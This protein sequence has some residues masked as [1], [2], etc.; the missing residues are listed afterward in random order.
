MYIYCFTT[1]YI[2]LYILI[3]YLNCDKTF[4]KKPMLQFKIKMETSMLMSMMKY[5][6]PKVGYGVK[7]I[8]L[9]FSQGLV[10]GL[11]CIM[12]KYIKNNHILSRNINVIC[13]R[14][15]NR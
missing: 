12:N 13:S 10:N 7:T 11:V 8:N 1:V 4:H 15:R 9:A 14:L 6:L 5:L 3:H 2:H